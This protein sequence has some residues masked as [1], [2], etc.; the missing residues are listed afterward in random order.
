MFRVSTAA[1]QS[2][3]TLGC[4]LTPC[5]HTKP[6]GTVEF[7]D[8]D[9]WIYSQDG[10][11]LDSHAL[12][13]WDALTFEAAKKTGRLLNPGPQLEGWF[14]DAGFTDISVHRQ[15]IPLGV[16]PKNKKLV[17]QRRVLRCRRLD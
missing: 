11:L 17:S 7:Q 15:P 10:S 2:L 6:G 12:H 14:K 1:I 8:M 9:F 4:L 3:D 13:R 16:W 5:R